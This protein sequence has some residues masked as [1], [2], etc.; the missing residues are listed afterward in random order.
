MTYEHDQTRQYLATLERQ[1]AEHAPRVAVL[2]MEYDAIRENNRERATSTEIIQALA[3]LRR[4]VNSSVYLEHLNYVQGRGITL[5]GRA[6]ASASVL[7]M[8]EQLATDPLWHSL[9]VVQLRSEQLDG[10]DQVHF[11]VEGRLN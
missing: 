2:E 3:S 1:F 6:P 9:R 8:T 7:E 11:V 4:H 5:R 10:V